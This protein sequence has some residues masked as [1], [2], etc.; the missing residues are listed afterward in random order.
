MEMAWQ[1][2]LK[3]PNAECKQSRFINFRVVLCTQ[4]DVEECKD[5]CK[6]HLLCTL[7][8]TDWL[9]PSELVPIADSRARWICSASHHCTHA[10]TLL[11]NS[12]TQ[13]AAPCSFSRACT[14]LQMYILGL[15]ASKKL[16]VSHVWNKRSGHFILVK[17]TG[18]VMHQQF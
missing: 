10:K 7:R 15:E 5:G 8:E 9:Q 12:F 3:F 1:S 4:M 18:Y 16:T 17:P 11:Q 14:D 6:A 2:F 13:R